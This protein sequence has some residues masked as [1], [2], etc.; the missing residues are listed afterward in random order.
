[1]QPAKP[2]T[3]MGW[4]LG[5][6]L[7]IFLPGCVSMGLENKIILKGLNDDNSDPY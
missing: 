3:G 6:R 2:A 7:Q 4:E 5:G 1:M